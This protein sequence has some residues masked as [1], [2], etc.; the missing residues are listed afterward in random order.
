MTKHRR[1]LIHDLANA[2]SLNSQSRGKGSSR[3]PILHKTSRTPRYTQKTISYIDQI[4]SK[5]R[6]NHAAT[7]SW[8]QKITKSA[9]SPRGRPDSSVSY[10][11]GDIVGASAPE[12]GAENKG[13][14]ILERM[15]WSTGTALGATN[16]KGILL[17]VAHVVKNTKA[18]LG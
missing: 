4:F 3:F 17:P 12:I 1:K 8:D 14:A 6:F 5:G 18:G 10:M 2:L 7:K 16:N 9:K 13:R 15:G 11:D